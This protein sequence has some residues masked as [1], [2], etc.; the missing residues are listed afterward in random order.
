MSCSPT[1]RSSLDLKFYNVIPHTIKNVFENFRGIQICFKDIF[2][3][4]T[5]SYKSERGMY[6]EG[7]FIEHCMRLMRSYIFQLQV[8]FCSIVPHIYD[9]VWEKF[10]G[11]QL[12]TKKILKITRGKIL[13]VFDVIF[14]ELQPYLEIFSKLDILQRDSSYNEEGF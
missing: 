2:S 1:Q 9:K 14:R 4:M 8:K 12:R 7:F 3:M 11:Q 10:W 6:V 5:N 13:R